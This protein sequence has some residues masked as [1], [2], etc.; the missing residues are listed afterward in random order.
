VSKVK[1]NTSAPVQADPQTILSTLFGLLLQGAFWG[2]YVLLQPFVSSQ[3]TLSQEA[4][5]LILAVVALDP[6]AVWIKLQSVRSHYNTDQS[7]VGSHALVW[8]F[9]ALMRWVMMTSLAL[10]PLQVLAPQ[11]D[12][13]AAIPWL[14]T[15]FLVKELYVFYLLGTNSP[16]QGDKIRAPLAPVVFLA[17]LVLMLPGQFAILMME[18]LFDGPTLDL[19]WNPI[20]FVFMIGVT[21]F[22]WTAFVLPMRILSMFELFLGDKKN[23]LWTVLSTLG[24]LLWGL[25]GIVYN[26]E[27]AGENFRQ[28]LADRGDVETFEY[29][30]EARVKSK[31]TKVLC[32]EKKFRQITINT[33]HSGY[34][35]RCLYSLPQ[36][37]SLNLANNGLITA[38]IDEGPSLESV[39]LSKNEFSDIFQIGNYREMKKLRTLNLSHNK[40]RSVENDF[41]KFPHL[42]E[43]NLSFNPLNQFLF[44]EGEFS[45]LKILK[46][47]GTNL[48]NGQLQEIKRALPY[49]RVVTDPQKR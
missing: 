26:S 23:L 46:L 42:Q 36:L 43:L 30:E 24:F 38:K 27:N 49:T 39:D 45:S 47:I 25:Q 5:Y 14:L 16:V 2:G 10:L 3:E 29:K 13:D 32:N 1:T 40:I 18:L 20:F 41:E 19:A 35:D 8:C 7:V 37:R 34:F 33:Q 17:D 21:A 48:S 11:L 15:G 28:A 22:L 6:C 9:F 4:A 31:Y 44:K 12:P